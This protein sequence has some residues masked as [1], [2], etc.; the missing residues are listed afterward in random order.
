M[1]YKMQNELYIETDTLL[2]VLTKKRRAL[3]PLCPKTR[4][5]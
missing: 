4:K 1:N 5:S 3:C 2:G